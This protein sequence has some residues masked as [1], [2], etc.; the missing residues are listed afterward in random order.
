MRHVILIPTRSKHVVNMLNPA[1]HYHALGVG[2]SFA[3]NP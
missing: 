2:K 3:D 1:N